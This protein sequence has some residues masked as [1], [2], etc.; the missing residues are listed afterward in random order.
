ML[1]LMLALSLVALVLPHAAVWC[2]EGVSAVVGTN[3]R[4]YLARGR[5]TICEL[6][7]GLYNAQWASA[8]ANGDGSNPG[9]A[10]AHNLRITV[11]GGGI[12]KGVAT[13]TGEEKKLKAD[14]IFSPEQDIA[15]NSLHISAEFSIQALAG[16]TWMADDKTGTFPKDFGEVHLFSEPIRS[17]KLELPS[18]EKL[19]F[20]FADA[21]PVLLQDNRKWGPSFSIRINRSSSKENPF[22]KGAPVK[23][24]FTLSAPG[25]VNVEHDSPVTIVAGPEWIPLNLDLVIEPG[26]ALD[27][28]KLGLQDAPVGK[29]GWL[30]AKDDG[31][32]CFEKQ[33]GKPARF[34][35]VNFCFS[36]LYNSHEQADQVAD[37]LAKLGYN[38]VRVHHYE[39]ELTKP[40]KE[41][42]TFI[43]EKLDQLDYLLAAFF[44]RGI[45]VTTDLF[46]S[47]PVDISQFVPDLGSAR[48]DQMNGYKA[49]VPINE[50]AWENWTAFSRN[51]LNHVNPYTERAY[52]DEPGFAW[53]SLIN[54]G[55]LGNFVHLIK[56]IPDYRTAWNKWLTEQYKDRAGLAAA[57]GGVLKADEDPVKGNVVLDGNIYNQD[58]RGRD[59]LRFLSKVD[60]DFVVRA[61][62]FLRGEMG[63]KALITNLNA[64]T[65]PVTLQTARAEMDY[66]DDHFY[67]DHPHFLEQDWRLPSRCPNT[68]PIAGGASGGR[69]VTFS[70]LFDKP[71]T[72]SEYNY[73]APGR[74]RGVGGILTGSMG[75]IQG[76][77]VIWRFAYS[78]DRKTLSQPGA[79][80]YFDMSTDP[81]GQAAERASICLFTRG[82]MQQAPHGINIA[83]TYEDLAKPPEKI[84][85]L[86]PGWNWAA[87]ITRVGTQVVKDPAK[88]VIGDVVL[89]LGW[90]TPSSAYKN[91]KVAESGDPYK[92]KSEDVAALLK[93]SG[94]LK[95]GNPTDPG[96][97]I[98]QCETGEITIDAPRDVMT[99]DTPRTAGGFAPAG[100][101]IVTRNG[102]EIAV[103][104][105]E[106]TVWVSSLDDQPIVSSKRLLISH[107]TDSQ[108]TEIRYAER[109]R[110]TLLAWGKLP[111]LVRAGKA[112]V[113][114]KLK[115]AAAYKVWALSTSGKRVAEVPVKVD[116]GMLVVN[117]DVAGFKD[118]GAILCYEVAK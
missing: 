110:Q 1:R 30:Q 36:A 63:M 115:D 62:K 38:T 55:N 10:P 116:G 107:L 45:Y 71:Y 6:G 89:P 23:I 18:G 13:V 12:V 112:E 40:D 117:T 34:Y 73:S 105:I 28:S 80:N 91:A 97:N 43:P 14:Y 5:S 8:E 81:L 41:R 101:K 26:S 15:L 53:F 67:V 103:Q 60:T 31:T 87:W 70:R 3:G 37:R 24:G 111:H 95:D 77:G 59:L 96:K 48:K 98:F 47:R 78:H 69:N 72:L 22:K 4:I 51:L 90:A 44:K 29:H 102:V 84:P 66:V 94:I 49:L 9:T 27:F 25:G 83:M 35:G 113:R 33:P 57:W 50:K 68:S 75:A 20:A 118:H 58:A 82:D 11:P 46:V 79:M 74:Y 109:A 21:T 99:L 100:E 7:A 104:E 114:V 93:K 52:K 56:E 61:T 42:L 85:F 76:W 39:G 65:N 17:L 92:L 64:W 108:N 2:A 16:G 86:S 106:A 54:E 19:E 32:F 88:P